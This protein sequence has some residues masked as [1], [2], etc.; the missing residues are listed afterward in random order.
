MSLDGETPTFTEM[1]AVRV[2]ILQQLVHYARITGV[3]RCKA[4]LLK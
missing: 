3:I 2:L 4:T 1:Q